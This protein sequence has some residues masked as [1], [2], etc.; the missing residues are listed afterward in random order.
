MPS[1]QGAKTQGALFQW[2]VIHR[3]DGRWRGF[4]DCYVE[5][6]FLLPL[7][8][9]V[10]VRVSY[11]SLVIQVVGLVSTYCAWSHPAW[12]H[13]VSRIISVMYSHGP[14]EPSNEITKGPLWPF[15]VFLTASLPVP[16]TWGA[17]WVFRGFPGLCQEGPK[18]LAMIAGSNM[19]EVSPN[20]TQ[21][22]L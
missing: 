20:R 6:M 14:M 1:L 13:P 19:K 22:Q 18:C 11:P 3:L 17:K 7:G 4:H 12:D 2:Q 21:P 9:M 8:F 10:R 15:L 16:R 5:A